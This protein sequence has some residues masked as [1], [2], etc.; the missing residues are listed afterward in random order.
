MRFKLTAGARAQQERGAGHRGIALSCQVEL[1]VIRRAIVHDV[2]CSVTVQANQNIHPQVVDQ[3][4]L[5]QICGGEFY[6][7]KFHANGGG[8]RRVASGGIVVGIKR[9]GDSSA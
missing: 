8:F 9:D 1:V 6:S 3:R 4:G 5:G 2:Q 7:A